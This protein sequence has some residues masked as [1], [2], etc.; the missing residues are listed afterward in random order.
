MRILLT[1]HQFLPEYS[2]GTEVLTFGTAKQ[3]QAAGHEVMVFTGYPATAKPS[4]EERFDS[5]EYQG[6]PVERYRH[7]YV[8]LDG[9]PTTETEYNNRFFA[10]YFRTFLKRFKPDVVHFFHL[11]RLSASAVDVCEALGIP[12]VLTPTDFWFVCPTNQL[13]LP[14]NSMC[15]GPDRHSVN[16][17]RHIVTVNQ[18][19]EAQAKLRKLPDW[20]V[21]LLIRATDWGL[22]RR[23]WF[24]PHVRALA[25]RPAFMR[26]RINKIDRVLAPTRLMERILVSNGLKPEKVQLAAYGIDLTGVEEVNA[27]PGTGRLRVAFIGT[28]YEHKGPHLLLQALQLLPAT[29]PIELKIYGNP[30]EFPAYSERLKQLAGGDD[31]VQFGGTFPNHMIGEIFANVDVLVVPSLWYENTPLVIYHAQ[32][33][34]CPVIASNLGGMAEAV[35]HE[36]NGLLFPAGNVSELAATLERLCRDPELLA[37]L[38]ERARRPKSIAEYASGAEGV[39]RDLTSSSDS[40]RNT[41]EV[42]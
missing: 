11:G 36:D 39:Y 37:K 14:D 27:S 24:A 31:R 2:A 29:L 28:L 23:H 3:L 19:A 13:R 18:S 5:Y 42:A 25:R 16:C 12:M 34:R 1:V 10:R 26:E 33:Y 41:A 32:A 9:Q 35:G 20:L 30:K 21:A 17:L 7:A 4:P 15:T 22:F 38:K 40:L 8:P 6:V